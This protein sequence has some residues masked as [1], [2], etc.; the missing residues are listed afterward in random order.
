MLTLSGS[1][2]NSPGRRVEVA[3][4]VLVKA[5]K[6]PLGRATFTHLVAEAA[7]NKL[8]SGFSGYEKLIITPSL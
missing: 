4:L 5:R 3:V 1:M 2:G 6:D 7:S 8:G